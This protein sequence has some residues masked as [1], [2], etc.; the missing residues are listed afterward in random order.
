MDILEEWNREHE[1]EVIFKDLMI[2]HLGE[3]IKIQEW[4]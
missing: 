2:D 4:F 3:L 1:R